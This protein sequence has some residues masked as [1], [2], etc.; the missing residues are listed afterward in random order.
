MTNGEIAFMAL[1]LGAF[2]TFM[3]TLAYAQWCTHV[4]RH[5]KAVQTDTNTDLAHPAPL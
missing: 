1:V 4:V 3:V 2:A 5:R